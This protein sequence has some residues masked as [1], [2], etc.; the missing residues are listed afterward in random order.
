MK[1]GN[2]DSKR[3]RIDLSKMAA[4]SQVLEATRGYYN[5]LNDPV[6]TEQE[7]QQT[8][9]VLNENIRKPLNTLRNK[10]F[11]IDKSIETIQDLCSSQE[12][13]DALDQYMNPVYIRDVTQNDMIMIDD[14]VE[15]VEHY[16]YYLEEPV[17]TPCFELFKKGYTTY[18][19]SANY[20][21]LTPQRRREDGKYYAY[22][23]LLDDIP[24][25]L[26]EKLNLQENFLGTYD[27]CQE[28]NIDSTVEEVKKGFC[29]TIEKLP[30]LDKPTDRVLTDFAS[31]NELY[32]IKGMDLSGYNSLY[33]A[34]N[35]FHKTK[36]LDNNSMTK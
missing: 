15:I 5:L 31:L 2:T 3:T 27:I 32:H 36:L 29:N 14:I 24:Q 26:V 7:R 18:S 12:M 1:E 17:V 10:G 6:I 16:R 25:S 23:S 13:T 8:L 20:K 34:A 33:D 35:D 11:K 9:S 28:I 30:K 21:D 19:S 22:I 4:V